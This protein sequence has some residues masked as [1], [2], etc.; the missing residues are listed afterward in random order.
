MTKLIRDTSKA[1]DVYTLACEVIPALRV[2]ARDKG[3]AL[4]YHGSF[5]RDIDLIAAP[6][7]DRAVGPLE[8]AEAIRAEAE[9]VTG[10][11]AFVLNDDNAAPTDYT[12]RFPEP[13]PHGRLGWS[14]H[15]A[16]TGAYIDLSVLAAG[17][18][19]SDAKV[20]ELQRKLDASYSET[21]KQSKLRQAAEAALA[22][23]N[24]QRD[25][26]RTLSQI[27]VWHKDCRPN[28]E[29][30]AR[31]LQ[32]SQAIID[33]LADE[34]TSLRAVLALQN[35]FKPEH[36]TEANIIRALRHTPS[37]GDGSGG[38]VMSVRYLLSALQDARAALA[39]QAQELD[40]WRAVTEHE[41]DGAEL[42]AAERSRQQR[43]EGWTPQHDDRHDDGSLAAAA[44]CY[45]ALGRRQC[46]GTIIRPASR[47]DPP[48]GWP[49]DEEWWK[50]KDDPIRNFVRAGALI[51]AEIDRLRRALPSAAAPVKEKP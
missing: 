5:A 8:L 37:A 21:M 23:S 18:A 48:G 29:M 6:W 14:I 15:L 7:L 16:G 10:H 43:I 11:T 24:K 22:L 45:A 50:P 39:L 19:H 26:F 27:G 51:A 40:K 4:A 47:V 35:E 46:D 2:V 36:T 31:E 25:E 38:W 30:A 33:K 28:R 17:Q 44:C 9:R 41:K 20:A 12:R 3:Y 34:I 32:K 49:F 1:D 42:I 13:K